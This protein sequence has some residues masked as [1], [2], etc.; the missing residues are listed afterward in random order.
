[1]CHLSSPHLHCG[2][3]PSVLSTRA[4]L[5][6]VPQS[7]WSV[8]AAFLPTDTS[9]FSF[10]LLA[11]VTSVNWR[12]T[13]AVSSCFLPGELTNIHTRSHLHAYHTQPETS[14]KPM[15]RYQRQEKCQKRLSR[16]SVARIGKDRAVLFS[17]KYTK[18]QTK[19]T[20]VVYRLTFC[21]P[22]RLWWGSVVRSSSGFRAERSEIGIPTMPPFYC[23]ATLGKLF[24]HILPPR[25]P[26][27]LSSKKTGIQKGVFGLDR[28]N[29]LTDW[30]R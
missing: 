29:D 3:T 27:L 24:T 11:T 21:W 22:G 5:Q 20:T 12:S 25:L 18:C 13:F 26:S 30:V 10:P 6:T 15:V 14:K 16:M 19:S 2:T 28:F 23:I 9:S 17:S 7:N 1:M 4:L 8:P